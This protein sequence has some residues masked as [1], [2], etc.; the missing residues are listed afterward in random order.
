V[1]DVV[2]KRE[3]RSRSSHMLEF[4]PF[5]SDGGGLENDTQSSPKGDL[6]AET[7]EKG[8]IR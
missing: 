7:R 4:V 6:G 2:V 1:W 5:G 3:R 8:V